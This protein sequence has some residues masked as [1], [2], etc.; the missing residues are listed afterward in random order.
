MQKRLVRVGS[1]LALVI[2]KALLRVMNLTRMSRLSISLEGGRLVITPMVGDGDPRPPSRRE[3]L[4][5]VHELQVLGLTQAHFDRLAPEP[6]RIGTYVRKVDGPGAP[7]PE[8]SV[9]MCRMAELRRLL[10]EGWKVRHAFAAAIAAHPG[11]LPTGIET[12]F[13]DDVVEAESREEREEIDAALREEQFAEE[14]REAQ[15]LAQE[16]RDRDV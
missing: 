8:V 12:R 7:A 11:E 4:Q 2:D 9:M 15:R 16:A 6:M 3:A 5:V 13:G 14:E 1:S 10:R